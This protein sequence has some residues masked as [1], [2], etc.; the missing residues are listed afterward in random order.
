MNHQSVLRAC[1]EEHDPLLPPAPTVPYRRVSSL[2]GDV[3]QRFST[4]FPFALPSDLGLQVRS[5]LNSEAKLSTGSPQLRIRIPNSVARNRLMK[6]QREQLRCLEFA[7]AH[8]VVAHQL[9]AQCQSEE[10]EKAIACCRSFDALQQLKHDRKRA[11]VRARQRGGLKRQWK[12]EPVRLRAARL[13]LVLAPPEGWESEQQAAQAILARLQNFAARR[14][15]ATGPTIRTVR[16][17][18]KSHPAVRAA[19]QNSQRPQP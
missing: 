15:I 10:L 12:I 18:I 7:L 3:E 13:L 2:L 17:W 5:S 4:L 19:Y 6:I 9:S 8:C 11:Y 14:R 16:G 1:T